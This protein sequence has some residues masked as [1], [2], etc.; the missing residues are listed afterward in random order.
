MLTA[1][2]FA[3]PLRRP[4]EA[5]ASFIRNG[6]PQCGLR[7]V[8]RRAKPAASVRA[9]TSPLG[10]ACVQTCCMSWQLCSSLWPYRNGHEWAPV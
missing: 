6:Q 2:T 1:M 7:R 3:E 5:D 9:P 10:S 4:R 8:R